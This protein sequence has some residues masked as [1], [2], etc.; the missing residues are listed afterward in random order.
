MN[1]FER[2]YERAIALVGDKAYCWRRTDL[3]PGDVVFE[4]GRRVRREGERGLGYEVWGRG[5]TWSE[6]F[7]HAHAFADA[8]RLFEAS[9]GTSKA[10]NPKKTGGGRKMNTLTV[11]YP[12]HDGY[13]MYVHPR[14]GFCIELP[15]PTDAGA[16]DDW[17]VE[18]FSDYFALES[19]GFHQGR[20]LY[21]FKQLY[22]LSG[23]ARVSSVQIA[24][25]FVQWKGAKRED[26]K[27]RTMYAIL[28]GKTQ[29]QRDTLTVVNPICTKVRIAPHQL[30]EVVIFDN[31]TSERKYTDLIDF[32]IE[33]DKP[34]L[35]IEKIATKTVV[36]VMDNG[37]FRDM[38]EGAA[39][40]INRHPF[41]LPVNP[42]IADGSPIY[43]TRKPPAS[44]VYRA[45]HFF[46]RLSKHCLGDI[47]RLPNGAYKAS[48]VTFHDDENMLH[49]EYAIEVLVGVKG[50]H[51]PKL[52][53]YGLSPRQQVL[54]QENT[55]A[56]G[57]N[58]GK[59]VLAKEHHF[60]KN[61][62]LLN[63][64]AHD[65]VEFKTGQE[66]CLTVEIAPPHVFDARCGEA[67]KWEVVVDPVWQFRHRNEPEMRLACHPLDKRTVLG[68]DIQRFM[69]TPTSRGQN[70]LGGK[71]LFLG[72]VKLC[73]AGHKQMTRCVSFYLV[74]GRDGG[75][76]AGGRGYTSRTYTPAPPPPP[77]R[78]IVRFEE[79]R[80]DDVFCKD[81]RVEVFSAIKI[82]ENNSTTGG[83]KK[84][85]ADNDIKISER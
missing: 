74:P 21:K 79:S 50:A 65:N 11:K 25:V 53:A 57:S 20:K 56:D 18:I 84:K 3:V 23:W 2:E 76:S 46:Y 47:Q 12:S 1:P 29:E 48:E 14:Q 10:G 61:R 36:N 30:L 43:P 63:P 39:F 37:E 54:V 51:K 44:G 7:G 58:I 70:L 16:D 81:A 31:D 38:N 60:E 52:R 73:V 78:V 80:T 77:M 34:Y 83:K 35:E 9:K 49:A 13:V 40:L 33:G 66:N 42:K 19:S 59:K 5:A 71:H 64:N 6:A 17:K 85:K 26:Y 15:F 24:E 69:V 8:R 45:T 28:Q 27:N 67:A 55:L 41:T 82:E 72:I 68:V 75:H 32:C 22:D 62:L 4:I